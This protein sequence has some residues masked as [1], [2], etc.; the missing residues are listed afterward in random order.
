VFNSSVSRPQYSVA[1]LDEFLRKRKPNITDEEV[2]ELREAIL[3]GG[4]GNATGRPHSGPA[5]IS[6]GG[7]IGEDSLRRKLNDLEMMNRNDKQNINPRI[8][9]NAAS[10]EVSIMKE[11][12][13]LQEEEIINLKKTLQSLTE[14]RED[15]ERVNVKLIESMSKE[16]EDVVKMNL[17]LQM[18]F[19]HQVVAMNRRYSDLKSELEEEKSR[20]IELQSQYQDFKNLDS[21]RQELLAEVAL[22]KN[23]E[24]S[25]IESY[26]NKLKESKVLRDTLDKENKIIKGE[27]HAQQ[28]R[29]NKA[30]ERI[31]KLSCSLQLQKDKFSK[32]AIEKLGKSLKDER[33]RLAADN[34]RLKGD[35][36]KIRDVFTSYKAAQEDKL[37]NL[38]RKLWTEQAN[39]TKVDQKMLHSVQKLDD[40]EKV[41]KAHFPDI[42]VSEPDMIDALLKKLFVLHSKY[43]RLNESQNISKA[44]AEGPREPRP[45]D[46]AEIEKHKNHINSLELDIKSLKSTINL[47]AR[48][49]EAPVA[50]KPPENVVISCDKCE[51]NKE[52][53]RKISTLENRIKS[54]EKLQLDVNYERDRVRT[55]HALN[56]D[57]TAEIDGLTIELAKVR[58]EGQK[59][60]QHLKD[61]VAHCRR[62]GTT[63]PPIESVREVFADQMKTLRQVVASILGWEIYIEKDDRDSDDELEDGKD[64]NI[65]NPA[66]RSSYDLF[67]LQLRSIYLEPNIEGSLSFRNVTREWMEKI[68]LGEVPSSTTL[69]PELILEGNYRDRYNGSSDASNILKDYKVG[70]SNDWYPHF[71]ALINIDDYKKRVSRKGNRKGLE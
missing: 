8:D 45:E 47:L 60:I 41:F 28:L 33:N 13:V 3:N 69:I 5:G 48:Q 71:F 15:K 4:N 1:D 10:K 7:N 54:L 2:F 57:L 9:V 25:I 6:R 32:E 30:H 39:K 18:D 26:N 50:E 36:E 20:F 11:K 46:L 27:N 38:E 56:Q 37:N 16:K 19:R 67:N 70:S 51:E 23:N 24:E 58:S 44:E 66:D 42:T 53:I 55:A 40:Y 12:M 21:E 43:T 68:L 29:L 65:D 62:S 63:D 31:E 49:S 64:N 61:E 35:L 34:E 17:S 59:E 22:L 52:K 14:D